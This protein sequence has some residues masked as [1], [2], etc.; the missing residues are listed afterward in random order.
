MIDLTKEISFR[1][2]R[3]GGKGGQNVNKVETSVEGYFHLAES[4]LLDDMQKTLIAEKLS[5]RIN[6]EVFL[7]VNTLVFVNRINFRNRAAARTEMAAEVD[8]GIVL[9]Y[10]VIIR[11]NAG[12]V[13][14]NYPEVDPVASTLG[15]FLNTEHSITAV[16]RVQ[17]SNRI[18]NCLHVFRGIKAKI[19]E[20]A[21]TVAAGKPTGRARSLQAA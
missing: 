9:L 14:R 5:N 3:S 8:E 12:L 7:Q 11:R 18:D 4:A 2:S 6:S 13:N 17:L 20:N 16:A 15:Q 19:I 10:V 21:R 1:T